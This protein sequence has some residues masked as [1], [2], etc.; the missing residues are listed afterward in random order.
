MMMLDKTPEEIEMDGEECGN[1]KLI[2]TQNRNGMQ[3][4]PGEFIDLLFDGNRVTLTE[5][6]QHIPQDPF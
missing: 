5:A 2:V 6:N 3:H 1:K 4:A